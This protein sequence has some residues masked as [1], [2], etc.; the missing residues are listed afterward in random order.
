MLFGICGTLLIFSGLANIVFVKGN[1][2]M[3]KYP[4]WKRL[5]YLKFFAGILISPL[6]ERT[7]IP[8][9]GFENY[10]FEHIE[11]PMKFWVVVLMY[12]ISTLTKMI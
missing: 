6:F 9:L 2:D 10:Y 1:T 7:L 8:I 11:V 5:I 3:K 12:P 4:L